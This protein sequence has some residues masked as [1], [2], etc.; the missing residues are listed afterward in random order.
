MAS[1]RISAPLR[2]GPSHGLRFLASLSLLLH[3][4]AVSGQNKTA[5]DL[6]WQ[7]HDVDLYRPTGNTLLGNQNFT[8]C[9]VKAV[10]EAVDTEGD[11]LVFRRG[12]E[13]WIII[14]N[15]NGNIS[16]LVN[17]T[18]SSL[19][20]CTAIYSEGSNGAPIVQVPYTWFADVCP[21]WELNDNTNLNAWLQPLSGFL[22]PAVIFCLS[23]PR[24]RKLKI[25]RVLFSLELSRM[26]SYLFVIPNA[27]L[28]G[29]MVSADTI[30]WLCICFALAGPMILSGLYEA[31][32]DNRVLDFIKEKVDND[33]LTLDMRCR[34]LMTILIGNLDMGLTKP[35]QGDH[36]NASTPQLALGHEEH[37]LLGP[38]TSINISTNG[39]CDGQADRASSHDPRAGLIQDEE[40]LGHEL[41]IQ[42]EGGRLVPRYSQQSPDIRS[43]TPSTDPG[44]RIS[45]DQSTATAV[46]HQPED[47]LPASPWRH[48]EKL[49]YDIRLYDADNPL[50]PY[51]PA[52][53][54]K[55]TSDGAGNLVQCPHRDKPRQFRRRT[56][57]IEENILKI[58][59]RL[60]TML[61]CQ[62][63]FGS[64]VGAPVVYVLSLSWHSYSHLTFIGF[65]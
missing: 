17:Y 27:I 45:N 56:P 55:C 11:H 18:D 12:F 7:L 8:W 9:C 24:S 65:S 64:I 10:Q 53:W 13:D 43:R 34:L 51:S 50:Q 21:G 33:K 42:P 36:K 6:I 47:N 37:R 22:L 40:A 25:P 14:D 63:S 46:V 39:D 20:P 19:F 44:H 3:I 4:S 30:I 28:A 38:M 32:L 52:Q 26:S 57:D 23:V 48:M 62:Y 15:G 49:L 35:S 54:D 31:L 41:Q 61:H 16:D 1:G 29:I 5:A 58:K 59:T 60:R 2:S